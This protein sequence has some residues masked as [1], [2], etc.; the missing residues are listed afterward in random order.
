MMRAIR[1][2]LPLVG[3]LAIILL[4]DAATFIVPE[5]MQAV[6]TQF[7]RPVGTPKT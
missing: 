7:G 5:G 4:T 1:P 2:F 6:V 3:L